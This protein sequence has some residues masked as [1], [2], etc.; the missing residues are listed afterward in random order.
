MEPSQ[1]GVAGALIAQYLPWL[2]ATFVFYLVVT[3]TL[4]ALRKPMMVVAVGA[5]LLWAVGVLP[6]STIQRGAVGV[7]GFMSETAMLAFR[8]I[9]PRTASASPAP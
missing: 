3:R 1:T 8:Q 6:L 5:A 7:I 4:S 9:A 2:V